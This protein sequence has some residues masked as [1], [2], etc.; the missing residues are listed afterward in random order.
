MHK[1]KP[2]QC[3]DCDFFH[4]FCHSQNQTQTWLKVGRNA[5]GGYREALGNFFNVLSPSNCQNHLATDNYTARAYTTPG[6]T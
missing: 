6:D 3:T 2:L 4:Q 1:A 5:N